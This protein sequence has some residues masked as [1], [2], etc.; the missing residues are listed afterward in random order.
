MERTDY[1]SGIIVVNKPKDYTSRDVVNK[2]SKILKTKK[3]GHT[4]TLDPLA[5]GVLVV[6]YGSATKLCE[7]LTSEYKEYIA[8]VKLGI[9]TDTLDITGKIIEEKEYFINK[10]LLNETLNSF[11]GE[12]IQE[13]PIYSAVKV[14]GK[15]LY[16][17]A[18]EGKDVVLPKRKIN[19]KNIELLEM[20]ND[21]FKFKVLVSKGTYI[22]ALIDDICKKLNTV[23]TMTELIRTSQGIFTISDSYTLEE[24]E[25][26]RFKRISIEE[27]LVELPSIDLDENTYYRVRNGAILDKTTEDDIICL[28]YENKVVAIYKTYEKDSTKCKP[29]KMFV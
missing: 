15:K 19:I 17:Y 27:A 3:V 13:V 2:I 11:L 14:C 21:C 18:R 22:R 28:K 7:L 10:D 12:C 25:K 23:G 29:F 24:I 20:N 16:E 5:T 26:E 4:G 1:M 9:K 6:C 8:T